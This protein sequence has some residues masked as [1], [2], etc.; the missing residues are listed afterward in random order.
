M[1]FQP[2]FLPA[3]HEALNLGWRIGGASWNADDIGVVEQ[4][5]TALVREAVP[6]LS[7]INTVDDM[8]T[9]IYELRMGGGGYGRRA[10]A[11]GN[12]AASH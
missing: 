12:R 4:V 10:I 6:F 7:R 11:Y 1:F 9:A 5:G 8:I 2:L 3:E